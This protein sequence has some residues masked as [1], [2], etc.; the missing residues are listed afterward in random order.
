MEEQWLWRKRS[1]RERAT[2]VSPAQPSPCR[3]QGRLRGWCGNGVTRQRLAVDL[4]PDEQHADDA[5][6]H[7]QHAERRRS[8][9]RSPASARG[10]LLTR[11]PMTSGARTPARPTAELA[12]ASMAARCLRRELADDHRQHDEDRGAD[13]RAQP[14][15]ARASARAWACATTKGTRQPPRVTVPPAKTPRLRRLGHAGAIAWCWEI[16][17]PRSTATM[18]KIQGSML[19]S[20][21]VVVAVAQPVDQVGGEPGEEPSARPQ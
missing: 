18:P 19:R 5:A 11:R 20:P 13:R 1:T 10:W 8:P 3:S 17:P 21:P 7:Q 2:S 14:P 6:G 15:A 16:S 9:P 4:G 12:M